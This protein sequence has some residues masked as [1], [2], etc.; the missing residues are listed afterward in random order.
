MPPGDYKLLSRAPFQYLCILLLLCLAFGSSMAANGYVPKPD[1]R[2]FFDQGVAL[3][4]AGDINGAINALNK[5]TRSDHQYAEA[6]NKL[7]EAYMA[8]NT[9]DART[10]A[11][12]AL[13]AAIILDYHN[14]TYN[15]NLGRLHLKQGKRGEAKHQFKNALDRNP[16]AVDAHYELGLLYTHDMLMYEKMVSVS[17]PK[18]MV[19]FYGASATTYSQK[20]Q[21][22]EYQ[23]REA[24]ASFDN[25]IGPL[26]AR[27]A[28]DEAVISGIREPSMEE[29][30]TITTYRDILER[31][32]DLVGTFTDVFRNMANE[33]YASALAAFQQ[34]LAVRPEDRDTHFHLGLL[35]FYRDDIETMLHHM[36]QVVMNHP[37]D[38]EGLMGLGL[39]L[40][41]L[42]RTDE[43][44]VQWNKAQAL[45][46]G[47]EK[48]AFNAVDYFLTKE[49]MEAVPD[50]DMSRFTQNYWRSRDPLFLTDYNE[51]RIEHYARFVEA[52]LRFKVPANYNSTGIEAID[53]WRT[54]R[55]MT[56]IKYGKP[57]RWWRLRDD[58]GFRGLEMWEYPEFAI[59]FYDPYSTGNSK[60]GGPFV[61]INFNGVMQDIQKKHKDLYLPDYAPRQF[62]LPWSIARFRGA[63]NLTDLHIAFGLPTRKLRFIDHPNGY[64]AKVE[65][66]I[67]LF[68]HEWDPRD[69]NVEEISVT[70]GVNFAV[71]PDQIHMAV[72]TVPVEPGAYQM[73]IEIQEQTDKNTGVVR[74]PLLARG[75]PG[76][77]LQISDVMPA[78]DIIPP[79]DRLPERRS[80]FTIVP[81]ISRQYP[82]FHPIFLYYEIYNMVMSAETRR[83]KY[84]VE[85]TVE[86][87][88]SEDAGIWRFAVGPGSASR[89]VTTTDYEGSSS[90]ELQYLR[91][92][93]GNSPPG[94]YGVKLVVRDAVRNQVAETETRLLLVPLEPREHG[95]PQLDQ[96]VLSDGLASLKASPES[97]LTRYHMGVLYYNAQQL[98][99]AIRE[100]EAAQK[101]GMDDAEVHYCLALAWR[102]QGL[103]YK[104][105]REAIAARER[106]D[107]PRYR[108]LEGL[109]AD[110]LG[111]YEEGL[112]AVDI[113]YSMDQMPLLTLNAHAQL[114]YVYGRLTHLPATLEKSAD[115]YIR[116]FIGDNDSPMAQHELG[117]ILTQWNQMED[118][119]HWF[120]RA[121]AIDPH[122]SPQY[123][124][125]RQP[126]ITDNWLRQT[127]GQLRAY[128]ET[129]FAGG[130]QDSS[131]MNVRYMIAAPPESQSGEDLN[132][133]IHLR[134]YDARWREMQQWNWTRTAHITTQPADS[135]EIW[136][137][138]A[139]V[140]TC[141]P[142]RRYV[143]WSIY[144]KN[145]Q[146]YTYRMREIYVPRAEPD[147][148]LLPAPSLL[149]GG[150]LTA[151]F[152]FSAG[153]TLT[154]ALN[155]PDGLP[156]NAQVTWEVCDLL[157]KNKSFWNKLVS[158]WKNRKTYT[159]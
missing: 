113:N 54:D 71:R 53:G 129:D 6:L 57:N 64:Q 58:T 77:M 150:K 154:A 104:A 39:G 2:A 49:R 26:L 152:W 135:T 72:R 13:D 143:V 18:N 21:P 118:A 159:R 30:L 14:T 51:R 94:I 86:A 24:M 157:S 97:P 12:E 105:Y 1:A 147:G 37:K 45:M 75:F 47:E 29:R 85:C 138:G 115:R 99:N 82:V 155:L 79:A 101:F 112:A 133:D 56:F 23:Q 42:N 87:E 67:F 22:P 16:D 60:I 32:S 28:V 63:N 95:P 84:T 137:D 107:T 46:E 102:D 83:T 68:D 151:S 15:V 43:A 55:G 19:E 7:A 145:S 35:A 96:G 76:G 90:T 158:G 131:R 127:T 8:K 11:E 33:D 66:G 140:V 156:A 48:H 50:E 78:N 149:R 62:S 89:I 108:Q 27:M 134:I 141:A 122:Y 125:R 3:L 34:V 119:D 124:R 38:K 74:M 111:M 44:S 25:P 109:L 144:E 116:S 10:R 91:I 121:A 136:M 153:D 59:G 5:A 106:K 65:R 81:N 73:A 40:L 41:R 20:E 130:N 110:A 31:R 120:G 132:L 128:L 114:D 123:I 69:R 17:N 98:N 92:N 139:H 100:F 61:G 52:N 142:G 103:I 146:R 80:D 9:V 36:R 148:Q 117:A 93:V 88:E 4:E 70:A 126:E